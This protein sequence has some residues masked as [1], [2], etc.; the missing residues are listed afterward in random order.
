[1][2]TPVASSAL[3]P[4]RPTLAALVLSGGL[5]ACALPPAGPQPGASAAPADSSRAAATRQVHALF[6]A[7]WEQNLQRY[8]QWATYL[9][10]QRY[11]DRLEDASPEAE[12]AGYAETRRNLAAAQA[13]PRALLSA[14]DQ[15]SLDLFVHELDDTLRFEPLRGYRRL[16]LGATGGF[17][18]G[19]SSLL[20]AS[21]ADKRAAA[22]QV[23][24]RLAAYPR[25]VDQELVRLREG[26]SL[27]WVAPGAVLDR[28]LAMLDSQL[29]AVGDASPFFLPFTSLGSDIPPAEQ[30]SLRRRARQL[31][32][33]QVL[34]AQRRLRDFVA[35]DYRAAAPAS[36]A[37]SSYPGGAAVYA[38]AVRQS[39]TTD[40]SPAQIHSIG[41]REVARL[42]RDIQQVM[43]ELK[44]Q[45]LF[46]GAQGFA[47]HMLTDPKYFHPSP[48]AL[49]ASYRDIAKRIDAELPRLF[50][51][52]PRA[53][54]GVRAMPAHASPDQAE[55]YSSPPLDGS[56]PGWF[57]ANAQGY[58][59]R[60]TWGQE[61]L[62]AH[63]AVPGHHLQN[64]RAAELGELPKFRRAAWF[65]AYG[66][67]WALYA[68]TLGFELGLYKDPAS[69]YGHLQDQMLRACRLVVDTGLHSLGW[70]PLRA[71]DYMTEHSGIERGTVESEIDR[72][73]S[74]PGQALGYMIG[75][76]K[77]IELRDRARARLGTRFDIRRFHMVL[78]DQGAVPLP[79]L[80]RLVDDWIAVEAAKS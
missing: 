6:D 65:V 3:R 39:T 55:Y 37:M 53:P 26:I 20:Q 47:R 5:A 35:G 40:L 75:Q 25:R 77:I 13:I 64:A 61:T 19:F 44:W 4:S 51:E 67:G 28:V 45:G 11:G 12:A 59:T 52:L 68:E 36:G 78:L 21:P 50:A 57:N 7:A 1:M 38:A 56:L 60:P 62:T 74:D 69:R 73:L 18:T 34:P 2:F 22:E 71:A 23:L 30:D 33:E 32:A 43:T 24:A 54:Y 8:P 76:L 63:E 14:T 31:I 17:H 58:K 80:E 16:S 79:L 66:E 15:T 9:G 70:T 72:Y 41:L 27:G 48:E 42:D 46:V 49:L 10:D 29:A